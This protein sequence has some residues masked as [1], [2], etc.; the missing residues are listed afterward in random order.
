MNN[1]NIVDKKIVGAK[2]TLKAVKSGIAKAVYVASDADTRVT[3]S[4]IDACN[5]NSV[6]LIYVESMHKL[7]TMCSIEVGAAIACALKK[8]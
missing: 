3:K 4:V 8:S 1:D 2:Q 6:E 7:G 5:E